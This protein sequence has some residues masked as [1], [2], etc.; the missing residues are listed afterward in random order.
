MCGLHSRHLLLSHCIQDEDWLMP[1]RKRSITVVTHLSSH[2]K[3]ILFLILYWGWLT[4]W[5]IFNYAIIGDY[6]TFPRI[7]MGRVLVWEWATPS[8]W[9]THSKRE[10]GHWSIGISTAAVTMLM[11]IKSNKASLQWFGMSKKC[12][13]FKQFSNKN[14]RIYSAMFY[15]LLTVW[16][17]LKSLVV[18][19]NRPQQR[20]FGT[21]YGEEKKAC[22]D[23]KK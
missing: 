3:E 15:H 2:L 4:W 18:T 13:G 6:R 16:N 7:K 5:I 1:N 21:G 8:N 10:G 12:Q 14:T 23:G 22:G 11:Q 20:V 17:I 9:L 19:G